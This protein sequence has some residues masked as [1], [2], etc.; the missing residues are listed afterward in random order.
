LVYPGDYL[1]VIENI[2][3]VLGLKRRFL[4]DNSLLTVLHLLQELFVFSDV[5]FREDRLIRFG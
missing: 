3:V 5:S 2:E 4:L 1:V